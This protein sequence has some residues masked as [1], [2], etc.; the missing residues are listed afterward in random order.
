MPSPA[1]DPARILIIRPSA[2]GDVARSVPLLAA[3]KHAHPA[4]AI[5]WLVQDTFADAIRHHPALRRVILFPRAA[6]RRWWS[7]AGLSTLR[8]F[9]AGLAAERYDLVLDAQGLARSA[10]FARASAAPIRI[11]PADARELGWLGYTHPVRIDPGTTHTVDRMLALLAAPPLA[12]A[13]PAEPD[14][15]LYPDPAELARIDADPLLARRRFA[16][17]APTSRWPGKRWPAERFAAV[18]EHLISSAGYDAAVIVGTESERPQC[19]PLIDLARRQP[20]VLDRLGRTSVASLLALISRAALVIANDSAALHF[21]VGTRTRAIALFGPTD[22]AKV[23]P[24]RR[25]ADVLQHVGPADRL[26]H[27]HPTL[28]SALM[29]R[30]TVAEVLARIPR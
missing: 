29:A 17:I 15:T 6:L 20:R 9:L 26:D 28:G 8:R 1:A 2:L 27:K 21:A 4:A 14:L 30:I 16:V 11:G 7:P 13:P 22:A 19:A 5:D 25:A 10:L 23:G 3:L 18:A 24:Y 12:I